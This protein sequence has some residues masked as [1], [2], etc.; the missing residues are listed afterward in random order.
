MRIR[1]KLLALLMTAV[2]TLGACTS[3]KGGADGT[4]EDGSSASKGTSQEGK[5]SSF[6]ILDE[7]KIMFPE[8]KDK[9]YVLI[10]K[11]YFSNK[12]TQKWSLNYYVLSKDSKPP[13]SYILL[14]DN[15]KVENTSYPVK[16]FSEYKGSA[17]GAWFLA[18]NQGKWSEEL[19]RFMETVYEYKKNADPKWF[20]LR[21]ELGQVMNLFSGKFREFVEKNKNYTLYQGSFIV[22]ENCREG[23]SFKPIKVS[24]DG[25]EY[26]VEIQLYKLNGRETA[27]GLSS[28]TAWFWDVLY[29]FPS[30]GHLDLKKTRMKAEKPTKLYGA[31]ANGF[32]DSKVSFEVSASE[33]DKLLWTKQ[34][35][36]ESVIEIPK[37]ADLTI[38]GDIFVPE[39]KTSSYIQGEV[40]V[41]FTTNKE[42]KSGPGVQTYFTSKP[43]GFDPF[44]VNMDP[45]VKKRAERMIEIW[46]SLA[47][48][49]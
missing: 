17:E 5:I 2:C 29:P 45:V 25:K 19:Y 6:Q 22:P 20:N 13:V 26:P 32:P 23:D 9:S 35:K 41:I 18:A 4:P 1:H 31:F 42:E 49:R 3:G 27:D 47:T 30:T 39:F 37:G 12:V 11:A 40:T 48:S 44:F 24:L 43:Q 7:K 38:R 46:S 28:L 36:E 33:K 8:L 15:E 10:P 16:G 34:L 14:G 21:K